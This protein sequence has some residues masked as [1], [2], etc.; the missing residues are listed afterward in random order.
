MTFP[1]PH[2]L[3]PVLV[4]ADQAAPQPDDDTRFCAKI[5]GIARNV[6]IQVDHL[7][8]RWGHSLAFVLPDGKRVSGSISSD[9]K[10]ALV[11]ACKDLLPHIYTHL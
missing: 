6:G 10:T 3:A 2:K 4:D 9:E 5:L 8:T 1:R 11:S 7:D